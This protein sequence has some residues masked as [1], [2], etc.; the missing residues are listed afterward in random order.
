M[1]RDT[2]AA[3]AWA[4]ALGATLMMQTVNSFMNQSLPIIAP[5]L[6]A[7]A[8]LAP[9]RIGNISSMVGLGTVLFLTFGGPLL[10]RLGPVR[11]LQAGAA[12][13]TF[14]LL[15]AASGWWP[16]LLIAGLL[17]GIGYGPSPPAGARILAATAPPQ[18]RTLIFSIKQAGAPAGGALAG[19]ILAPAAS[20][21]GWPTSLLIAVA[22]GLGTAALISPLRDQ[23]DVERNPAQRIGLATLLN[24]QNLSTPYRAVAA[25]AGLVAITALA[26]SFAIVQG[27]LFS[28]T[29]TYLAVGRGMSLPEAGAAYAVLQA[30]GVVARIVLGWFADRTGR[31]AVNLTVQAFLASASVVLLALLPEGAPFALVALV[32]GLAGFVAASWNGIYMAEVVRLSA[33]ER[34]SDSTS[35][36]SACTFLGYMAG[37]S[38]FSALVTFTGGWE[39]SFLVVAAQL[40]VMAVIQAVIL[41]RPR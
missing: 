32:C 24:W 30:A 3:P 34:I 40:A 15:I 22:V 8:G 1:T 41:V 21:Y 38:I 25:N 5:L 12:L 4:M 7:G 36:S 29:V 37:P 17:M 11:M 14:A 13:T 27:C 33:P 6:T 23:L 2:H 35:G 31:P 16:V 20:A 26:V 28:F 9:E 39:T 10:I 18:H 19:L